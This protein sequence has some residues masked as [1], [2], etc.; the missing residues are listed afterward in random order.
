MTSNMLLQGTSGYSQ[1]LSLVRLRTPS[2]EVWMPNSKAVT[3]RLQ[4]SVRRQVVLWS[5]MAARGYPG[6]GSLK[7]A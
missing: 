6:G 2:M 3:A 7:V 4:K 1:M 5:S